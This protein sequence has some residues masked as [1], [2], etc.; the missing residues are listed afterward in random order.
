M[1]LFPCSSTA[2]GIRLAAA[3]CDWEGGQERAALAV[4]CCPATPENSRRRWT[5]DH[6]ASSLQCPSCLFQPA[7]PPPAPRRKQRRVGDQSGGG[8]GKKATMHACPP[9]RDSRC[10]S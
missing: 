6:L 9:A 7:P 8:A 2:R 1:P 3:G 10:R 5:V 4:G